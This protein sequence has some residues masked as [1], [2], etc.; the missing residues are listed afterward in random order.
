MNDKNAGT[1]DVDL[2]AAGGMAD[3]F[4]IIESSPI[5]VL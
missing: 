1:V 3:I 5:N 4:Y 2:V